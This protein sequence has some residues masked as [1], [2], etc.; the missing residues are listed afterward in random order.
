MNIT[1]TCKKK[2]ISCV[3]TSLEC[4]GYRISSAP[5]SLYVDNITEATPYSI[6][7]D[8]SDLDERAGAEFDALHKGGWFKFPPIITSC[9]IVDDKGGCVRWPA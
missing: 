8:R 4:E 2:D 9:L 6:Y 5:A 7:G 3:I 1:V